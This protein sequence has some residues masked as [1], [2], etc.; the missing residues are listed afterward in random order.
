MWGGGNAEKPGQTQC[1]ILMS[2]G[3]H[4]TK[5]NIAKWHLLLGTCQTCLYC[6]K[7]NQSFWWNNF[8][9]ENA[10][11]SKLECL[12]ERCQSHRYFQ[13]RNGFGCFGKVKYLFPCLFGFFTKCWYTLAE[14][15]ML[16]YID[17]LKTKCLNVSI[18]MG[19]KP[20]LFELSVHE[21]F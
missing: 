7:A 10:V 1:S 14:F 15:N 4:L 8:L 16:Y 13:L 6:R 9:S 21:K 17:I 3:R 18:W 5:G 2:M 11:L 19:S 20:D 12:T